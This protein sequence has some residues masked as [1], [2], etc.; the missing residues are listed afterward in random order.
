MH[1][2]LKKTNEDNRMK[3]RKQ[4]TFERF[5]FPA[6]LTVIAAFAFGCGGGSLPGVVN[7]V[8]A[9]FKHLTSSAASGVHIYKPGAGINAMALTGFTGFA[10]TPSALQQSFQGKCTF[11]VNTTTV[12]SGSIM[13]LVLDRGDDQNCNT[14]F[15]NGPNASLGSL[16]IEDGT[17]GTLVVIADSGTA[18]NLICKDLA[19]LG[20]LTDGQLISVWFRPSDNKVLLFQGTTQLAPTCTVPV[21][22]GD[23][24]TRISAQFLKS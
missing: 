6:I 7:S 24:V 12:P 4:S 18:Q 8:T 2:N 13:P 1:F 14:W 9:Q 19:S 15:T 21:P 23:S 3:L 11:T 16:V 22:A 20:A 5:I 17:V 10:A